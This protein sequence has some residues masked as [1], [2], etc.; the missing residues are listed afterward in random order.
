MIL[1]HEQYPAYNWAVNKGY[2]TADHR[3]ALVREGACPFHR[4]SFR[5]LPLEEELLASS[6]S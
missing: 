6:L 4:R 1:A 3:A 2:P 5:L